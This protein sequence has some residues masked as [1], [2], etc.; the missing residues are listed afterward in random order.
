MQLSVANEQAIYDIYVHRPTSKIVLECPGGKTTS[1][2]N[3]S[4]TLREI[5]VLNRFS[6]NNLLLEFSIKNMSTEQILD[7][8]VSAIGLAQAAISR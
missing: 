5:L 6:P 4:I 7:T 1:F 8:P 2:R 3:K